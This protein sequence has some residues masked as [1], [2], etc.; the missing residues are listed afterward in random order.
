MDLEF[1]RRNNVKALQILFLITFAI[2]VLVIP[3]FVFSLMQGESNGTGL[4]IF[5]IAIFVINAIL[6]GRKLLSLKK[7]KKGSCKSTEILTTDGH[8]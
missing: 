7:R 6:L 5:I 3:Y 8:G 4:I 2:L 1:S